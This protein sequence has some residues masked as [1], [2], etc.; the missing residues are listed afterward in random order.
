M[1]KW[2][3]HEVLTG[4][5]S[6]LAQADGSTTPRAWPSSGGRFQEED[7]VARSLVVVTRLRDSNPAWPVL[8]EGSGGM[9]VA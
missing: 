4:E 7:D 6:S 1:K 2:T 3:H 5:R 9:P 8:G